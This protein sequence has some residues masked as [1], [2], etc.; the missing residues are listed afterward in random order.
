VSVAGEQGTGKT[1]AARILVSLIDPSTVPIRKPPK[2]Q[3]AWVTGAGGSWVVAFDNVSTIPEWLSDALCRASTGDGDA[4]RKLYSDGDLVVFTFRRVI[5]L[6]SIDVG[7]VRGDL[8][9]RLLAADL[10]AIPELDRSTDKDLAAEW[11]RPYPTVLGALLSL[12]A[13]VRDRLPGVTLT[14]KPRM[15]DLP[16]CSRRSMTN[17]ARTA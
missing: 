8:A 3:E 7:A 11:A 13:K 16:A 6:T 10:N 9:D 2:D 14:R 5:I 17:S 15:A 12:A 1:S 4:R